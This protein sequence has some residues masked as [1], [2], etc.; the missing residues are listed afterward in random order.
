MPDNSANLA[1]STAVNPPRPAP[2]RR[3][4]FG[5]LLASG[6]LAALF[7]FGLEYLVTAFTHES[8]DDAFVETGIVAISPKVAGLVSAV[9]VKDNQ[10]VN[11]GDPLFDIDPRD[12]E[13]TLERRRAALSV[14][15]SNKK[16]AEA[17]Y[18]VMLAKL[19]A[20]EAVARQSASE[21]AASRATA[22]RADADLRRAD[23]LREQKV[24]SQQEY[25]Q[26][27]ATALSA[28]ASAAADQDKVKSDESAVTA[29]RAQLDAVVAALEMV[30]AQIAQGSA[31]VKT[32]ELDLSYTRIAAPTDGAV[33]RKAVHVGEYVQVGQRLLAV[34]PTNVWVVANFKETQLGHIRPGM[35]V[36]IR[37]DAYPEKSLSGHVDS[38]QA[39]SGARFSLLPPENA[40]GNY[41]KVVQRVP[42]KILFNSLP[43]GSRTLAPGMSVVPSVRTGEFDPHPLVLA[44]IAAALAL[45]GAW[46][47]LMAM[48][49]RNAKDAGAAS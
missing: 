45:L 33:T 42:V 21:A 41:V 9:Y 12:Y 44:L 16:S 13:T 47:G 11:A 36:R 28:S 3:R 7:F 49:D 18:K 4:L 30:Q 17:A 1:A 14:S 38:I 46:I 35:P 19:A 39:G 34:V 5:F 10:W 6:I 27:R 40:V 43:D 24:L 25:D 26:V 23:S 8:T 48:P 2:G 37:V 32:A 20:A 15:E 22:D 29:A 31:E